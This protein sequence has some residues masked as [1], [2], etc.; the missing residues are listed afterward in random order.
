MYVYILLRCSLQVTSSGTCTALHLAV[1][2][3]DTK[4]YEW[5]NIY[6]YIPCCVAPCRCPLA[7][8]TRRCI[9]PSPAR[10]PSSPGCCSLREPTRRWPT[11]AGPARCTQLSRAASSRSSVQCC[12]RPNSRWA[13]PGVSSRLKMPCAPTCFGFEFSII[14]TKKLLVETRSGTWA[15]RIY[16][17]RFISSCTDTFDPA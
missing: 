2:G 10:T 15:K 3:K 5:M 9:C 6:L 11:A 17:V 4:L 16:P 12:P 13:L 1:A 8:V 7:L 14:K